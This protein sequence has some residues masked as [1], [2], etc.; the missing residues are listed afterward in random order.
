MKASFFRVLVVGMSMLVVS[1]CTTLNNAGM[2]VLT[3]V[4]ARPDLAKLPLTEPTAFFVKSGVFSEKEVRGF[5]STGVIDREASGSVDLSSLAWMGGF[6]VA[7]ALEGTNGLNNVWGASTLGDVRGGSSVQESI[8]E[9]PAIV[10]NKTQRPAFESWFESKALAEIYDRNGFKRSHRINGNATIWELIDQ[11][12]VACM[13]CTRAVFIKSEAPNHIIYRVIP[14]NR[15]WL[16]EYAVS[17]V[18]AHHGYWPGL[19]WDGKTCSPVSAIY[20]GVS[21]DIQEFAPM[22]KAPVA[23]K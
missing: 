3:D 1:G 22:C 2:R 6:V 18:A 9:V 16:Q 7:G 20:N 5:Q 17:N 12:G 23:G 10:V 11:K 21:V 14:R 15:A 8:I 4:E 13:P 19:K